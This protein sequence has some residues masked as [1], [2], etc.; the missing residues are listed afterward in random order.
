MVLLDNFRTHTFPVGG[1]SLTSLYHAIAKEAVLADLEENLGKVRKIDNPVKR[2]RISA[3][4]FSTKTYVENA[5][6]DA[7]VISSI[8]FV[9]NP[10]GP[11]YEYRLDSREKQVLRDF[12]VRT[13]LNYTDEVGLAPRIA[14][15][16]TLF[17]GTDF[18]YALEIDARKNYTLQKYDA[19]KNKVVATGKV[20]DALGDQSARSARTDLKEDIEQVVRRG[21]GYRKLLFIYGAS[22]PAKS[23]E[24]IPG[25]YRVLEGGP[26]AYGREAL[27]EIMHRERALENHG[28]LE[29]RLREMSRDEK[30]DLYFFG[31]LPEIREAIEAYSL[32]ELF[33]ETKKLEKL[34]DQLGS[35]LFNFQIYPIESLQTGDVADRFIQD[36]R[37]LMGIKYY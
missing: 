31:K 15:L 10:E 5:Y 6:E 8:F 16:K 2:A 37:G 4:Y 19:V 3:L 18:F 21:E 29:Q 1:P 24:G 11:V 33:I 9:G 27:N 23:Y 7:D 22:L 35:D 12:S 14:Y 25:P 20:G 30:M 34:K 13:I 32:K 17:D 28:I 26:G 36:Y